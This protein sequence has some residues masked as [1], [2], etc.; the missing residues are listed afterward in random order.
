MYHIKYL[1]SNKKYVSET[2]K[3]LKLGFCKQLNYT[4]THNLHSVYDLHVLNHQHQHAPIQDTVELRTPTRKGTC[5][6]NMELCYTKTYQQQGLLT[7]KQLWHIKS[8]GQ[9]SL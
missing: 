2:G 9:H 5:V 8:P 6:N 3:C 1:T 7:T 4:T